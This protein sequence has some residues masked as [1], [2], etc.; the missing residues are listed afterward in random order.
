MPSAH[1]AVVAALTLAIF[2]HQGFTP[3]FIVTLILSFLVIRDTMLRPKE[4]RHKPTEVLAGT[5]LG[6]IISYIIYII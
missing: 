3:L 4:L 5:L 6:L 1:S 2:F